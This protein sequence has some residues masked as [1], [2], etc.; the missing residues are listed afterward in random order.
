MKTN[1][2]F[3]WEPSWRPFLSKYY[4]YPNCRDR[5]PLLR[6]QSFFSIR[7]IFPQRFK[8]PVDVFIAGASF[9]HLNFYC[10]CCIFFMSMSCRHF[11][12]QIALVFR[13]I[14]TDRI[15]MTDQRSPKNFMLICS[16]RCFCLRDFV[17]QNYNLWLLS[18]V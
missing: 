2:F 18:S 5:L 16:R 7:N 4:F 10:I 12:T 1:C 9:H 11:F 8:L 15:Y 17:L 3:I 13:I 14:V 6:T